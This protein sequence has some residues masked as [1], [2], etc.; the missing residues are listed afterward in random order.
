MEHLI[1]YHHFSPGK[2]MRKSAQ[3]LGSSEKLREAK[4]PTSPL[5]INEKVRNCAQTKKI[6]NSL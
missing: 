1:K 6:A 3:V 4:L 5:I 2:Q